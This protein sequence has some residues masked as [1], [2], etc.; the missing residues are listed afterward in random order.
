MI[1]MLQTKKIY[2]PCLAWT[3]TAVQCV[4]NKKNLNSQELNAVGFFCLY[5]HGSDLFSTK[6]EVGFPTAGLDA[7]YVKT[8]MLLQKAAWFSL[9][10]E[11]NWYIL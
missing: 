6:A 1:K 8:S 11:I 10:L 5:W 3:T 9:L 7:T 4:K 2:I